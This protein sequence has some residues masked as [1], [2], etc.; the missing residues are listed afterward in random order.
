MSQKEIKEILH[1]SHSVAIIGLSDKVGKPSHRVAAYLKKHSFHIIPVNPLIDNV[2]GE[3]SYSSLTDI[4]INIQKT[5][6][7]IDIF[8][9][10]ENVP[11]IIEQAIEL[12]NQLGRPCV[13]WMQRGI[14]NLDAAQAAH[15]AGFEV[16]MDKCIMDEHIHLRQE[17]S[18]T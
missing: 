13:I 17:S 10:S 9:K 5:I 8:R 6:D 18:N 14:I 3:K 11:P 16:I 7:I 4:P 1:R 12:K 15:Q 2:L